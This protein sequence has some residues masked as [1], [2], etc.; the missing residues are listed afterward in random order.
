MPHRTAFS[1]L[2]LVDV[3][4]YNER[5]REDFESWSEL[6]SSVSRRSHRKEKRDVVEKSLLLASRRRRRPR[7]SSKPHKA[8]DFP[9]EIALKRRETER[10]GAR[11]R[12]KARRARKKESTTRAKNTE[13]TSTSTRSP[14]YEPDGLTR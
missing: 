13:R 6:R 9:V 2:F 5:R 1:K 4:F 11:E 7:A 14:L 8:R 3:A 12:K 10:E